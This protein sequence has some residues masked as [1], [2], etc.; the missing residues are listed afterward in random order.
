MGPLQITFVTLASILIPGAYTFQSCPSVCTCR[1]KNGKRW[2]ECKNQG[3]ISIPDSIDPE[4]QVLDMSGNSL[5]ILPREVFARRGLLNLQKLKLSQCKIG[6]ID[7]TAFRGLTNLVELDLSHN[8]LTSVPTPTF[9]DIPYLRELLLNNNPLQ[10]LEAHAFEMVPQL[11][12]LDVSGC[13]IKKVAARSF[14]NIE[15]LQ[16][17]HIHNNKIAE[18][19]N[20][21]V[22]SISGLHSITLH[23]N[24]WSCNCHLRRL[25]EWL[26]SANVPMVDQ[27]VCM[28]P[29][30]L[31][32][33]KLKQIHMDEFAC[34]PKQ[35][36]TLNARIKA[37]FGQNATMQCKIDSIPTSQVRWYHRGREIVNNSIIHK[38]VKKFII[39]E[40]VILNEKSSQL[41][42]TNAVDEDSGQYICMA[43]NKAGHAEANFTMKV[44][45]F[46]NGVG[47]MEVGEIAG[48]AITLVLLMLLLIVVILIL[49][50]K[51]K[52][53]L[54]KRGFPK[55]IN[56]KYAVRESPTEGIEM[57]NSNNSV[58]NYNGVTG[59]V[60]QRENTLANA[61]ARVSE[62][63]YTTGLHGPNGSMVI[64]GMTYSPSSGL[65]NVYIN[66]DVV[67]AVH[68][69]ANSQARYKDE[70]TSVIQP[71]LNLIKK[72]KM[73]SGGWR[74]YDRESDNGNREI[75]QNQANSFQMNRQSAVANTLN[76]PT[77]MR[78]VPSPLN[79]GYL[80][81]PNP[82]NRYANIPL[83]FN[84]VG[85]SNTS[86][87]RLQSDSLYPS[88][89]WSQHSSDVQPEWRINNEYIHHQGNIS[90][91][92]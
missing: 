66:P 88:S 17:L 10:K 89:I 74:N 63:N 61:P 85:V 11:V 73:E 90:M 79:E 32:K 92:T 87:D 70:S 54:L 50:Q 65:G 69:P 37:S 68:D 71:S 78:P 57:S 45:Y 5:N 49:L 48:I 75:E 26:I 84:S 20:K 47:G 30:R 8:L 58:V 23:G 39:Q 62:L 13:Q 25:M 38:G 6:Q 60:N 81:L 72:K 82:Q 46:S 9:S 67:P 91:E 52:P 1:W 36:K 56:S 40:N 80:T 34:A 33:K 19:R 27:P 3:Q 43:E 24:P 7:P 22:D 64:N 2:V 41:T 12:T 28:S 55:F 77:A 16:H 59:V 83:P 35:V 18:L 51:N 14:S 86:Y 53:G 29:N 76:R 42:V 15:R 44:G 4:I 31:I 21:T